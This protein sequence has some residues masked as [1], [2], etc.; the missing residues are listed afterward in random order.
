VRGRKYRAR[1]RQPLGIA[2]DRPASIGQIWRR[3]GRKHHR[4]GDEGSTAR[5]PGRLACFLVSQPAPASHAQAEQIS[6]SRRQF[7]RGLGS[8]AS[9]SDDRL[10]LGRNR[11]IALAGWL[12]C[13]RHM[14]HQDGM[15]SSA[16]KGTATGEHLIGD[17]A[18]SVQIR[19]MG[20][21][22][23]VADLLRSHVLRRAG[24]HAARVSPRLAL[25]RLA[26]PNP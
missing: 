11:G 23:E 8:L 21:T 25:W 14:G 24:H 10:Q 18:Q 2:L 6:A 1:L 13:A 20:D 16:S 15:I 22:A 26:M 12:R 3:P 9:S 4:H 17:A 5:R 19:E 7:A